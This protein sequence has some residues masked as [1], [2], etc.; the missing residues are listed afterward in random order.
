L[1]PTLVT[2]RGA[3]FKTDK[4]FINDERL[5]YMDD[6]MTR[7]WIMDSLTMSSPRTKERIRQEKKSFNFLLPLVGKM[8]KI[9]VRFLAGSD[10]P[11]PFCF[12]GFSLHDEL[13][14]F[15]EGGMDNLAAL[16][17]A[18][19]NPA[20]FMKKEKDYG[21][22]SV[23]KKASLVLLD[24]NPLESIR[25]TRTISAVILRGKAFLNSKIE[26]M[27]EE[28]KLRKTKAYYSNWLRSSMELNGIKLALDSL[29]ILL[30]DK[31]PSYRLNDMDLNYFGYELM[32]QGNLKAALQV[33]KKNTLLF[34]D[35]FNTFDSYGE[36]L[37]LDGQLEKAKANYEKAT[38]M[39]PYYANGKVMLDSINTLLSQMK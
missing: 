33:L 36:A 39:N 24:K 10:Y 29:D 12:P 7:G 17:T 28:T 31:E 2:N 5:N 35:E 32:Q 37:F 1:S 38:Q 27:L 23:G 34:P 11:N 18:T 25:N 26:K 6:Y 21:T 4:D 19:L 15:V 9:G 22:I 3:A 20:T 13:E 30:S 14:L 8:Q 16:Q